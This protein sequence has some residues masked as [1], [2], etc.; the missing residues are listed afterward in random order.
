MPFAQ[1]PNGLYLPEDV[2]ARVV[3]AGPT[4]QIGTPL[5]DGD[6]NAK[7]FLKAGVAI[8]NNAAYTNIAYLDRTPQ[9]FTGVQHFTGMLQRYDYRSAVQSTTT[10]AQPKVVFDTIVD[11]DGSIVY[12]GAGG[13]TVPVAGR[14]SISAVASWAANATGIRQVAISAGGNYVTW[15]RGSA[16]SAG[17]TGLSCSATVKLAANAVIFV[18]VVQ[19]SGGNLDVGG[20]LRLT[21][22]TITKVS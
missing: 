3:N 2:Y 10:G 22:V 7:R 20:V 16:S 15:E 19:T 14:Y 11:N 17:N 6:V 21:S 5:L 18:D 8:D 1:R 12:D 13:Y 9:T 4:P